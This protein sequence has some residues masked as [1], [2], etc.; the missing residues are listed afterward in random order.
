MPAAADA[1]SSGAVACGL[2]LLESALAELEAAV[3]E[4]EPVP[5][6]VREAQQLDA[7]VVVPGFGSQPENQPGTVGTCNFASRKHRQSVRV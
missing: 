4:L 5:V 7:R 2:E 1:S 6:P 3:L